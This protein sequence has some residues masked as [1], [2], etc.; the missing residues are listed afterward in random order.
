[1][2]AK[3]VASPI[4]F[5]RFR[6]QVLLD[7][8]STAARKNKGEAL[9]LLSN[10]GAATIADLTP[11]RIDG[12]LELIDGKSES[13]ILKRLWEVHGICAKAE[14]MVG[15]ANAFRAHPE[16]KR[17]MLDW[18]RKKPATSSLTEAQIKRALA[19]LAAMAERDN[20]AHRAYVFAALVYYTGMMPNLVPVIRVLDVDFDA[21]KI[22]V[23]RQTAK[24][25]VTQTFHM[26][27]DLALILDAW[28]GA[29]GHHRGRILDESKVAEARSLWREGHKIEA[30]AER[31]GV[32]FVAMYN[33]LTGRTWKDVVGSGEES[34]S[35][36]ES[37]LLLPNLNPGPV[38]RAKG[39]SKMSG[40]DQKSYDLLKAAGQAAGIDNLTF[41][42]LRLFHQAQ[43]NRRPVEARQAV[44]L[45]PLIEPGIGRNVWKIRGEPMEPLI[46]APHIRAI[47]K[48]FRAWT[49]G[50]RVPL[51]EMGD[52]RKALEE[53][54]ALHKRWAEI[55][56]FPGKKVRGG[57]GYGFKDPRL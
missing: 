4:P 53:V 43:F 24:G 30:L 17:K 2:P 37:E 6:D 47:N 12:V 5:A 33:A 42:D 51:K 11:E 57:I 20:L 23:S 31:Y 29:R 49:K 52:D 7:C 18:A 3:N 26:P 55:I 27:D 32:K 41:M 16:L 21:M 38:R 50:D 56:D 35:I 46:H 54:K 19:E 34:P 14:K 22:H 9:E 1:M 44:P 39:P 8:K 13:G 36:R 48:L 40:R 28:I 10:A 45:C 25:T 15:Q